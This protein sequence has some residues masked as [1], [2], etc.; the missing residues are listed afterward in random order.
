MDRKLTRGTE[1]LKRLRGGQAALGADWSDP[2]SRLTF[3][4]VK[5]IAKTI[6][7]SSRTS[8]ANKPSCFSVSKLL[9]KEIINRSGSFPEYKLQ[10]KR[11]ICELGEHSEQV[12]ASLDQEEPSKGLDLIALLNFSL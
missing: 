7:S 3:R 9:C 8:S 12:S 1:K 6:Y 2:E 5:K 11:L 4:V 10:V